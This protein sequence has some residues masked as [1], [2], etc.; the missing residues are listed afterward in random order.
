[1]NSS[2]MLHLR[3]GDDVSSRVKLVPESTSPDGPY[4]VIDLDLGGFRLTAFPKSWEQAAA[5]AEA[6]SKAGAELAVL[7]ARF[8]LDASALRD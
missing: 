6:L 4:A 2:T 1:M 7:A 5:L 3:D 8:Q